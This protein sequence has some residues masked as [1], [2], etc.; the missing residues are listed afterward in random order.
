[1]ASRVLPNH[2]DIRLSKQEKLY[3]NRIKI[4]TFICDKFQLIK[5]N[6]DK[7]ILTLYKNKNAMERDL[8]ISTKEEIIFLWAKIQ[9]LADMEIRQKTNKNLQKYLR[10]KLGISVIPSTIITYEHHP[11]LQLKETRELCKKL[12]SVI[13]GRENG[14]IIGRALK[15]IPLKPKSIADILCNT[16]RKAQLK[17]YR[18]AGEPWCKN[19][20]HFSKDLKD[21]GHM[22]TQIG[23][24]NAKTV[25]WSIYKNE[26]ILL[27][28]GCV[29][30]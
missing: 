13:L 26:Y 30:Y 23:V 22:F 10:N 21:M 17:I 24:T 8:R 27:E 29:T 6:I 3:K 5:N 18:C 9:N 14:E 16:N 7:K 15:L 28:N 25:P 12:A 2:L 11:Y 4:V 19:K 20:I 1:M